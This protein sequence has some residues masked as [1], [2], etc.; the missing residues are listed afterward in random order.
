MIAH[1]VEA[2]APLDFVSTHVYANDTAQDVFG[3]D[4]SIPRS[5]MVARAARKIS[6]LVKASARPDLPIHW[7]EYNASTRT[8]SR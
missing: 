2:H 3:T 4:E 7:T 6:N 1:C 8:K 5:E